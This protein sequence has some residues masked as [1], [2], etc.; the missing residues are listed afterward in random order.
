MAFLKY[1]TLCNQTLKIS[2]ELEQEDSSLLYFIGDKTEAEV[3]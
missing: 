3:K 2:K 1:S